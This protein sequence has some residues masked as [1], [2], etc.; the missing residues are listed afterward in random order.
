MCRISKIYQLWCQKWWFDSFNK[1]LLFCSINQTLIS[2]DYLPSLSRRSPI[3]FNSVC[4]SQNYENHLSRYS[5]A[6]FT[7]SRE[8]KVIEVS[9][10]GF[11]FILEIRV[12]FKDKSR[13]SSVRSVTKWKLHNEILTP[14][15]TLSNI[16][17]ETNSKVL[18]KKKV[19]AAT[20][21]A[22][23]E[24][25]LKTLRFRVPHRDIFGKFKK[26]IFLSN[27][28]EKCKSQISKFNIVVLCSLLSAANLFWGYRTT[29][30][31]SF[32]CFVP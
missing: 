14:L 32:S 31:Y 30:T 28:L 8:T 23:V 20:A 13:S 4:R 3:I 22:K 21:S 25:R 10:T 5:G 2:A 16:P 7:V 6:A 26:I 24:V 11:W 1:C 27:S 17:T 15:F 29:C 12:I 19:P 18:S 9:L